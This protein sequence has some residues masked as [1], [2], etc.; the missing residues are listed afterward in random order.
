MKVA[1]SG[2]PRWR[3]LWRL[4]RC[5]SAATSEEE[6]GLEDVSGRRDELRRKSW[7]IAMPMEAKERE[8]RSQARKVRS[9][10]Q[11]PISTR[12]NRRYLYTFDSREESR[13]VPKA[14]WSRATLP[15][16]SNSTLPHFSQKLLH[17]PASL[18]S[19]DEALSSK[20][21]LRCWGVLLS[22]APA[23]VPSCVAAPLP[24]ELDDCTTSRDWAGEIEA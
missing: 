6:E 10:H 23:A 17:H 9:V 13:Y 5:A 12:P 7:V 16:F 8:V 20:L 19:V 11:N 1:P 15:L 24:L 18:P 4:W 22:T 3:S 14:K 2:L 21:S